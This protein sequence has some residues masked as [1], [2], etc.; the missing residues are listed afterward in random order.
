MP[1][2]SRRL[3]IA[4]IA[5]ALLVFG[6]VE[7]IVLLLTPAALRG[8]ALVPP[9]VSAVV[10]AATL[11]I[12]LRVFETQEERIDTQQREIESLH[13]MDTAI[14]SEM[15]LPRVLEV[16][17][18]KVLTALD[19]EASGLVLF[20]P[21]S[22]RLIAEAYS[23]PDAPDE[24]ARQRF[25]ALVRAGGG[26]G[27]DEDWI[28]AVSPLVWAGEVGTWEGYAVVG[29]RRPGRE[30]SP[31]EGRLLNDLAGTVVLAVRNARALAAA[32][33][34]VLVREA[35]R[36]EKEEREREQAVSRA[37][38]EGLLPDI[39][40]RSGDWAFSKR[41]E[42]QSREAPVGGDIYDIFPLR[43]GHWGVVIADVS[44]KGLDAARRTAFVK[45]GLRVLAREHHEPARVLERLNDA[46]TGEG[47]TSGFVT[48]VYGIL[49]AD[50][51]CFRYASA[52]HETP[53]LRRADATF[54]TLP[55]TGPVL[56]MMEG[57]AYD[58]GSVRLGPG[59]GLLLFTDGLSE[60]R[61]AGE[62]RFLDLEGVQRYLDE[63]CRAHPPEEVAD[64]LLNIVSTYAGGRLSDDAALL[65]IARAEVAG[66]TDSVL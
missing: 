53:I 62:R 46:V 27:E 35:L 36:R 50:D 13:S 6:V 43:Q 11:P 64:A 23:L 61:S 21:Q 55:P 31:A 41:Y 5:I 17:S 10:V 58:Q 7:L 32:R 38:T 49:S 40:A 1:S 57:V 16:A 63:V 39:P 25:Q 9:L 29:R 4:A 30:F 22:G 51:G 44:G 48:V 47:D 66:Q 65:W 19:A 3:R 37:L 52:G 34:A 28:T 8:A 12:L 20:D 56:G 33:E 24:E 15:E 60:A 26:S 42:A 14:A 18:R 59:D 54:E 2:D 45:H